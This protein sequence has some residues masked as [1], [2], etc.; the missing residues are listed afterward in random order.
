[1]NET[2]QDP[3]VLRRYLVLAV[4]NLRR[5]PVRT[6]LTVAGVALAVTVAVSLGGFML[7]YRGAI[8]KSINMLGYQVMIMAK[9]CPYEA[10]TMMLKGGTGLL[11]LPGETY[12]QVKSDP[13]IESIT[14]I[15]IGVAEKQ[16]S[17]IR[18]EG[19]AS[20]FTVI[21]GIDV[22]SFLIMK[23]WL[24]FKKGPGYADGRWF[25]PGSKNEVVLGFEAAEYEQRKVGDSFYA[26]ITPAGKPNPVMHQFTVVG[27]L[28]RTGTQDDGTVFLP[29]DATREY[30]NR[31]NQLTIL[32]IKLKEF[33]SFRLREFETRWLKLPEV[34][35]VGL[36]QVKNTLVNL[37]ATAQTMIAAV[38][39]IAVIVALI[40]VVNTI[41]MSVYE[42]TAEIGIMKALGARRGSIFQLI[43]LETLMVCFAGALAGSAMAVIAAGLVE[44]AIKALADLGLSG[45][46]VQITPALVGYTVLVAVVLGFFAGLYPAWRASS[47]R[48]IEAIGKG[49]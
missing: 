24:G 34:Q 21:S 39:A 17:S 2:T 46:I 45:S 40:G 31:P 30:F 49:G 22:P 25:T 18:D 42:R 33:S 11:Y 4:K 7:G 20:N 23:P 13:D 29:I 41:L 15:F 36:Q 26:S 35:V 47:M 38:A 3:F 14:P 16:A 1:M 10:A 27:V 43:W 44:Q 9:G 6:G 32:G 48:P 37:V 5:R 19:A 8:D 28:E 12:Q